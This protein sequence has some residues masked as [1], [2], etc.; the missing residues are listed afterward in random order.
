MTENPP[1]PGLV[2]TVRD[3]FD[4]HQYAILD[5]GQ[6]VPT[7][8]DLA[9]GVDYMHTELKLY[10]RRSI[11][12]QSANRLVHNVH[13]IDTPN[14]GGSVSMRW[15]TYWHPN[16][17]K[18]PYLHTPIAE[19][20]ERF[21]FKAREVEDKIRAVMETAFEIEEVGPTQSPVFFANHYLSPEGKIFPPHT[22]KDLYSIQFPASSPGY[23]V[24]SKTDGWKRINLAPTEVLIALGRKA[25]K[26]NP[27]F[28][29]TIHRV[30]VPE[31]HDINTPRTSLGMVIDTA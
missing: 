8:A 26:L 28:H 31:D 7:G 15:G 24:R 25:W 22:D 19:W 27:T 18:A 21:Y 20:F 17:D 9:P 11:L 3:S 16:G 1:D 4:R 14:Y 13:F 2:E 30:T 10:K 23:K 29:G 6:P 5:V 12:F